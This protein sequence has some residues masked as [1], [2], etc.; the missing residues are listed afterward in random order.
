[1]TIDTETIV[2]TRQSAAQMR[3]ALQHYLTF[4]RAEIAASLPENLLADLP[5]QVGDAWIDAAGVV[6]LDGWI[7]ETRGGQLRLAYR[8]GLPGATTGSY[9]YVAHLEHQD[10]SWRVTSITYEKLFPA[11]RR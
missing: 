3:Q 9:Q 7:L 1:V 4:S 5:D 2:I 10:G 6:R 8:V 11:G